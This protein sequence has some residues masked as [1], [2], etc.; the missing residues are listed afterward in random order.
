MIFKSFALYSRLVQAIIMKIINM[1]PFLNISNSANN[2]IW[3]DRCDMPLRKTA[4][5]MQQTH[6]ISDIL[7][8]ILA[9]R[10][11]T[12]ETMVDYLN[13]TFK[14]L[15]PDPFVLQGMELAVSRLVKAVSNKEQIAIF[16]DYDVDGATSS[17]IL[18]LYLQE[19]GLS[20]F[21]HIPDRM[22][23]GYG[24][25]AQAIEELKEKGATLLVCVDCGTTSHDILGKAPLDVIVLDHHQADESLPNVVAVVNPKR[26]DD[27]SKLD[28]LAACGVVFMTIVAL[29]RA[30]KEQNHFENAPDLLKL[31][32]LVALGTVADIVP[33]TGLNRAF[34]VRGLERMRKRENVGL[35]ALMDSAGIQEKLSP[36]HLGFALGPRI[37]AGGRIGDAGLGA[38][39]LTINDDLAAKEIAH[40]LNVLNL[41]RQAIEKQAV[42]EAEGEALALGD[43][44]ILI[45]Q[46]DS[47]HAGVVGLVAAR[48]KEKFKRPAFAITFERGAIGTGSGRSIAGVD[49]GKAVR[50]AVSQGLLLKGGGHAMAA[51]LTIDKAKLGAFRAFMEE[52][53]AKSLDEALAENILLIDGAMTARAATPAFIHALEQAGPFGAGNPEP[54]FAFPS[55]ILIFV[56]TVG[57]GHLRLR[58]KSNDGFTLSAIAFRAVGQP[59]GDFLLS[60]RGQPVTLAGTLS[61]DVWQGNERVQ[62]RVIDAG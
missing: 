47:W 5:H 50:E 35:T 20:P 28:Y 8:R 12:S 45:T 56:D 16:G 39:L 22:S 60:K 41:E 11:V 30:L 1:T 29:N 37:N 18:A 38:R 57:T 23:E 7:A 46:G 26:Q 9:S 52:F 10:D 62:L 61:V 40:Q 14:N 43:A 44:P 36:Y 17:A 27:L 15:M 58:L 49:L 6:E 21:I 34:V 31:T 42:L 3:Q 13:P 32:D 25:N 4:A 59:L 54:V 55:H 2:N 53:L 19:C 51:G 24:P 33:L 48:L